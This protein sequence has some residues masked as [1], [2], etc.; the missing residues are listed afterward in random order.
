MFVVYHQGLG[1]KKGRDDEWIAGQEEFDNILTTLNSQ[2]VN[3]R[4]SVD[5]DSSCHQI[6]GIVPNSLKRLS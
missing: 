3:M 5:E 2:P 6:K 1:A 4:E